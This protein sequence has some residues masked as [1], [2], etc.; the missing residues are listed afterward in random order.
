MSSWRSWRTM[1]SRTA[2]RSAASSS[3]ARALFSTSSARAWLF[4]E[5]IAT[6]SATSAVTITAITA[7]AAVTRTTCAVSEERNLRIGGVPDAA[8]GP[9]ET[10]RVTELGA[11]LGHVH[12]DRPGAGVRG[13]PP[14]RGEQLLPGEHPA[15][16]SE[17][18]AEQV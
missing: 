3:T 10:G 13:I 6:G 14:D 15:G 2:G 16:P 1:R 18:V 8:D 4:A 17:Q 12:V 7:V 5:R 11:D 9:D